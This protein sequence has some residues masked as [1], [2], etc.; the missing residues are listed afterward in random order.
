MDNISVADALK[1]L[2]A[3]KDKGVG[4]FEGFGLKFE[5]G[6]KR[7]V[8]K[9]SRRVN[10]DPPKPLNAVDLALEQSSRNPGDDDAQE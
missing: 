9:V 7:A 2:D 3:C 8:P 4:S 10:P 6:P 1:L 5:L